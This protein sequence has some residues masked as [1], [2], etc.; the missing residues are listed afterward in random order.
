[1]QTKLQEAGIAAGAVL[2]AAALF[3]DPHLKARDAF[4][5][6]NHPEAGTHAHVKNPLRLSKNSNGNHKP[7]PCLGEHNGYVFGDLLGMT[8][9]EVEELDRSGVIGTTPLPIDGR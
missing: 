9:E 7:A 3:N 5:R 8:P 1:V 6:V 2:N 4:Y